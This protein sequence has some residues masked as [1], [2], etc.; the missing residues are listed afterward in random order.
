MLADEHCHVRL[1]RDVCRILGGGPW[2][3]TKLDVHS[4][5]GARRLLLDNMWLWCRPLICAKTE[6]HRCSGLHSQKQKGPDSCADASRKNALMNPA[7]SSG[8]IG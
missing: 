5:I 3:F 2:G 8:E 6:S 7:T 4:S 1:Q